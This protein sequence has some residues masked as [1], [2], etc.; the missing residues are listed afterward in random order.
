MI[1]GIARLFVYQRRELVLVGVAIAL[2]LGV[3]AV[4]GEDRGLEAVGVVTLGVALLVGISDWRLSVLG[5]LAYLPFSGIAI[6]ATY[7][8]TAIA[9]L[10]KDFIFVLPAYLGFLFFIVTRKGRVSAGLVPLS[11][12]AAL[13]VLVI[14]Q[15]FNPA[16]PN[17]LVGAIGVKIWLLYMPMSVL[18]YHLVRSRRDLERVLF[19]MVSAGLIPALI[20][21]TE[22]VLYGIGKADVVLGFYGDAAQA[23]T[24][25]FAVFSYEGGGSLRRVPS[26]FSFVAQY[27]AFTLSMIAVSYAWWRGPADRRSRPLR[28]ALVWLVFVAAAFLSGAR[29]GFVFVPLLVAV[30]LLLERSGSSTIPI[31][32]VGAVAGVVLTGVGLIGTTVSGVFGST[33]RLGVEYVKSQFIDG[34]GRAFRLTLAGLGAGI[35]STGARYAFANGPFPAVDGVWYE[36]WW[37]KAALELGVAG[38]LITGALLVIIVARG[39]RQHRTLVDPQIRAVSASVIAFLICNLILNVKTQY[40]DL[41]P[42]NVYFWFLAGVLG[43]LPELDSSPRRSGGAVTRQAETSEWR[44]LEKVL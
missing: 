31:V 40:M 11:L 41:D 30:I 22:A 12:A 36:S 34:F 3:G 26:T 6:I 5:L 28:H 29:A 2:A 35:D 20:G 14:G 9:V 37:V 17:R 32:R 33:I 13:A 1:E 23:V 4:V 38:L 27:F 39:L 7:P 42:T 18:G 19:I 21:L 44:L 10:A 16:L 25:N 8:D 24:Q 15:A 43:R